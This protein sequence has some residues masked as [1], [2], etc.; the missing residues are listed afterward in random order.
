MLLLRGLEKL[1]DALTCR[2]LVVFMIG[3]IEVMFQEWRDSDRVGILEEYFA[4][5][6]LMAAA[7]PVSSAT[8][9]F[10]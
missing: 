5:A 2:L 9:A 1:V 10:K 6:K 7:L 4:K 8:L 3:S